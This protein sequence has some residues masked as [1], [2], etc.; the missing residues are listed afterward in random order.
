MINIKKLNAGP[1]SGLPWIV[2]RFSASP[3]SV[4]GG[5]MLGHWGGVKLY[6]LV[7][8]ASEKVRANWPAKISAPLVEGNALMTGGVAEDRQEGLDATYSS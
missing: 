7:C 2:A 1:S 3:R 6:H 4:N 8:K 5:G